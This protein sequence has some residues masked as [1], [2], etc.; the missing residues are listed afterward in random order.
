MSGDDSDSD[1][2]EEIEFSSSDEPVQKPAKKGKEEQLSDD[3]VLAD[4]LEQEVK[5][6]KKPAVTT[7]AKSVAEGVVASGKKAAKN[8]FLIYFCY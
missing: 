6:K 2:G 4:E 8:I 1:D 5:P 7:S 3:D